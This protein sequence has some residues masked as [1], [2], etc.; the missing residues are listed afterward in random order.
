M[1]GNRPNRNREQGYR[2]Q[3]LRTGIE[4]RDREQCREQG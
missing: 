2:E 1:H 3:G 4:T